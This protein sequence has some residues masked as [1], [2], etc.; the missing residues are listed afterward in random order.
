MMSATRVME[1]L[2][3]IERD[4]GITYDGDTLKK[5]IQSD[6]YIRRLGD[7]M[8]REAS[9]RKRRNQQWENR[10][11]IIYRNQMEMAG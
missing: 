7:A 8:K 6:R 10:D 3:E 9:L 4:D 11:R 5:L 2:I 1:F